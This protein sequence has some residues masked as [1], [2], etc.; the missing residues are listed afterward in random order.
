MHLPNSQIYWLGPIL[1]AV[2]AGFFY[3]FIFSPTR[4]S[5]LCYRPK[6]F[7]FSAQDMAK[8]GS[9]S[10]LYQQQ[11]QQQKFSTTIHPSSTLFRPQ[12]FNPAIHHSPSNRTIAGNSTLLKTSQRDP[13]LITISSSVAHLQQPFPMGN[14][15]DKMNYLQHQGLQ[16]AQT[17]NFDRSKSTAIINSISANQ[18]Q[19]QQQHQQNHTIIDITKRNNADIGKFAGPRLDSVFLGGKPSYSEL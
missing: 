1:G 15:L 14:P 7:R 11:Q 5:S 10:R 17:A 4:K 3:E 19:Q 2:I 18:H 16:R 12:T 9:K 13:Q 8:V 6:L